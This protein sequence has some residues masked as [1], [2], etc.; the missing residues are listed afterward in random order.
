M[1]SSEDLIPLPVLYLQYVDYCKYDL[2][3]KSCLFT[4]S[5]NLKNAP[6]APVISQGTVALT[7]GC[8]IIA[9]M[10]VFVNLTTRGESEKLQHYHSVNL[11]EKFA[12]TYHVL[13]LFLCSVVFIQSD[14][15]RITFK[16]ILLAKSY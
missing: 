6:Q 11:E 2:P 1:L 4:E 10:Y 8:F 7:N 9:A 12:C 16:S 3:P 5:Y 14:L 15:C 13:W